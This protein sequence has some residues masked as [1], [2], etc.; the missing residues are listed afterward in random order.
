[1]YM[2]VDNNK[3]INDALFRSDVYSVTQS[4]RQ[5]FYQCVLKGA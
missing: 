1:M 4:S 3:H 5:R 2:T